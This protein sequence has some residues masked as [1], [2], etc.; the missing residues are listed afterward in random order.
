MTEATAEKHDTATDAA[1]R[2]A[3]AHADAHADTHA[4][5]PAADPAVTGAEGMPEETEGAAPAPNRKRTIMI[6]A[7]A[8]C[9]FGAITAGLGLVARRRAV[10][11]DPKTE[12]AA[13]EHAESQPSEI[14]HS[15]SAGELLRIAQGALTEKE[16]KKAEE[17]LL[18]A[19]GRSDGSDPDLDIA[20]LEALARAAEETGKA[21]AAKVYRETVASRREG[22]GA[23]LP[24]FNEGERLLEEGKYAEARRVFGKFLLLSNLLAESGAHYA[25]RAKLYLVEIA[26]KESERLV[27]QTGDGVEPEDY[28][29]R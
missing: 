13:D 27:P 1:P 20:I 19:R 14:D 15:L 28:F 25:R 4:T 7:G 9:L 24:M 29:V 6:A 2:P 16:W 12:H 22:L 18:E 26:E 10:D 23:T 5:V 21:N 3:A 8:L 11:H 17:L